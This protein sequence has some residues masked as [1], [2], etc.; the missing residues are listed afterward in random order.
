MASISSSAMTE[1]Y[2]RIIQPLKDAPPRAANFRIAPFLLLSQLGMQWTVSTNLA[3]SSHHRVR[4]RDD[5]GS[6]RIVICQAVLAPV[7]RV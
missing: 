5:R 3:K 4:I 1:E 6:S 2:E 7:R